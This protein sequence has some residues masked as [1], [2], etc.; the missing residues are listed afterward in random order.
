MMRTTSHPQRFDSSVII[1]TYNTPSSL[2][3]SIWGYQSQT[4]TDFEIIIADDG[5]TQETADLVQTFKD[6]GM[7]ITHLWQEDQGFRKNRIL[8]Q[9]IVAA[10]SPYCIFTDGD[11]IPRFDLIESH[12]R[13]RR[14]NQFLVA[15]SHVSLPKKF[16]EQIGKNDICS[17]D[18]FQKQWLEAQG[19]H[20][21]KNL[22][23]ISVHP[24]IRPILDRVTH[25]AGVFTGNGSSVWR[26]D[27]MAVNGFDERLG[28]G[29]EDKDFGLRLISAG[30]QSRMSKFSLISLHLDHPKPY[31]DVNVIAKNKAHLQ[32]IKKDKTKWTDYGIIHAVRSAKPPHH[33]SLRTRVCQESTVPV[34]P[35]C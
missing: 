5:S 7:C 4:F 20:S 11:C 35:A 10:R 33:A 2:E 25:R 27:A 12:A 22:F 29:G 3:K 13:L 26:A 17:S 9:A 24:L 8:N 19:H 34:S 14:K 28:Y 6:Q 30:I 21:R 32:Q 18:V 31:L 23:R 16:H 1:S 15:G